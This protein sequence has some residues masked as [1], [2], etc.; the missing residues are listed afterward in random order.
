MENLHFSIIFFVLL[1]NTF[2]EKKD[3]VLEIMAMK[4]YFGRYTD[5]VIV[6]WYT[7]LQ[8]HHVGQ[9][10]VLLMRTSPVTYSQK[11]L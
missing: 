7:E 10:K 9:R 11:M 4:F 8:Y 3:K 1:Q 6:V 2:K 5:T